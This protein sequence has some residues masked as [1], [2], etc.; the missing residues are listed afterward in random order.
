MSALGVF[1]NTVVIR[2]DLSGDP[3]FREMLARVY[4]TTL[5]AFEHEELPFKQVADA[6]QPDRDPKRYPL[7]QVMFNYLQRTSSQRITRRREL[8]FGEP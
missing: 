3:T 6:V 7:S 8:E 2:N 5:E 1:V 4:A